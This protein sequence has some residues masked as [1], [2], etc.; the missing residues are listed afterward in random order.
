MSL[1]LAFLASRNSVRF[2]LLHILPLGVIICPRDHLPDHSV[3]R[4]AGPVARASWN[5]SSAQPSIRAHRAFVGLKAQG[6][7]VPQ[8]I[9]PLGP[10]AEKMEVA[11]DF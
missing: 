11:C 3:I 8:G 7:Q 1:P 9:R 5:F 4:K 10:R 6:A 2:P